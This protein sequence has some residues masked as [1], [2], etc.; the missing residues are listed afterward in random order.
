MKGRDWSHHARTAEK[1]SVQILP[2]LPRTL[3]ALVK[4][5]S[6]G[7]ERAISSALLRRGA[8]LKELFTA[9][10]MAPGFNPRRPIDLRDSRTLAILSRSSDPR[11]SW[12][13]SWGSRAYEQEINHFIGELDGVI[14]GCWLSLLQMLLNWLWAVQAHAINTARGLAARCLKPR[15]KGRIWGVNSLFV[16]TPQ[17]PK[18]MAL[19]ADSAPDGESFPSDKQTLYNWQPVLRC[20]EKTLPPKG[21]PLL[22]DERPKK[23]GF[24]RGEQNAAAPCSPHPG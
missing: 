22:G 20:Y 3:W 11:G 6:N 23:F 15:E 5:A 4:A 17:N 19:S 12:L 10:G 2:P 9:D 7:V 1:P 16:L 13:I 21:K 14:V 18:R 24:L 8:L